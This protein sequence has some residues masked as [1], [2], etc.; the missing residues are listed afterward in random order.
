MASSRQT[1]ENQYND[2]HMNTAKGT[3]YNMPDIH[4][5]TAKGTLY[6]DIRMDTAKPD[7]TIKKGGLKPW[8]K[9]LIDSPEVRRKGTVAQLCP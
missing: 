3:L 5:G 4:M 2:I 8:E 9:A 7:T 1:K 6:N